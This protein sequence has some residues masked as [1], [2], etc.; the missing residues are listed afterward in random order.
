[1]AQNAPRDTAAAPEVDAV[2]VTGTRI[3][4][5]FEQ[6]TPVTIATIEQ[7]E[8]AQPAG[9][10]TSLNQLPQFQG[11]L[12]PRNAPLSTATGPF[13]AR[14]NYL[15]L[16]G[17]GIN[18][19][20]IL[21]DGERVPPTTATGQVDVNT[22]P[23]MLVSRVDVV[24]AGVSAV[25]GSD[26]V[27]GVVNYV[28]D[29]KFSGL[30]VKAQTGIS[31]Y[32]DAFSYKFG[33]A[34]GMKFANGRGSLIGSVEHEKTDEI[35]HR[36]RPLSALNYVRAGKGARTD[37]DV[38]GQAA[39]PI[40]FVP[41]VVTTLILPGGSFQSGPGAGLQVNA[42]GQLVP[43]TRG[44]Y[45]GSNTYVGGDGSVLSQNRTL[46]S[47]GVS[48]R[49]FGRASYDLTDKIELFAEGL[50]GKN[51]NP[52]HTAISFFTLLAYP[53][54]AFLP[55]ALKPT[56]AVLASNPATADT[57]LGAFIRAAPT[58][59]TE[60]RQLETS[61]NWSVKTGL[62][63]ELTDGWNFNAV[64]IHGEVKQHVEAYEV[65]SRKLFAAADSIVNP[66][67]GQVV[68]RITLTNPTIFPGCVPYN[69]FGSGTNNANRAAVEGFIYGSSIY[70][71]TNKTDDLAFSL[72][73]QPFSTWAGPVGLS[74]G[75]E[76]RRNTLTLTSNSDPALAL[77]TTGI[78]GLTTLGVK[79]AYNITNIG[80]A[81]GRSN[82][83]EANIELLIP[84]ANKDSA[85]G[86]VI[87]SGAGRW[88]NYSTSGTVYTWKGG[89][90]WEPIPDIRLRATRSRD[91]RAPTLYELNAGR[92]SVRI[93]LSDPHTNFANPTGAFVFGGGNP[94]LTPEK[95]DTFTA[96]VV[97]TPRFVPRLTVSLDYYDLKISDAITSLTA[98]Q[99]LQACENA[100]GSGAS[101]ANIERPLPFSDRTPANFPT[102][103]F[104]GFIN[105]AELQTK[106]IDIEAAY[107]VPVSSGSLGFRALANR[108]IR[109][110]SQNS[111]T[112]PVVS[113]AG[114]FDYTLATGTIQPKWRG[115]I[116]ANY[117][118]D[119]G[120]GLFLQGRYVGKLRMGEL[121]GLSVVGRQ[122]NVFD[123][124]VTGSVW[125]FDT[126]I[127][128]TIKSGPMGSEVELFANV[129]N[130]LNKKPPV[131]PGNSLVGA[132]YPTYMPL[133]DV[134][135][136]YYTV[137]VKMK[138]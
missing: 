119:S 62:R 71:T 72:S 5:G 110:A 1:M 24:T 49:M 111:T 104:A 138:F 67:N 127:S 37:A 55:N 92:T 39:F 63:G 48:T 99:V 61:E 16:R 66:A 22:I 44:T 130:L 134:M 38:P 117:K 128:Q 9:I 106:G 125:Y 27:T 124:K 8:V 60:P 46:I 78:R 82:V 69:P 131:I 100:G 87:V 13:A 102:S 59:L 17:V 77:N 91:I 107:S 97:L 70:D 52:Y 90:T 57:P 96:G 40:V 120:L 54:N 32:G 93:P 11:S 113:Q 26:A 65:D 53:Q 12:S 7:L 95:A 6:P 33:A 84:L 118:S 121:P 4:T 21:M 20:L 19:T 109:Y 68:C 34:G 25:Y 94:N 122:T 126:N 56:A 36:D 64:Y 47:G 133:Y 15:N 88:T 23:E 51:R 2:V 79:T 116:S 14:G 3:K 30:R 98:A 112:D 86:E 41:N 136:R 73:G 135:G 45:V 31:D 29:D 81:D 76:Y 123:H 75:A 89:A 129:N 58:D 85:I 114:Y 101:C 28:L 105:A 35:L 108:L 103:I 42:S 115:S 132:L 43:I 137:G 83:K 18:R 80:V 10:A 74:V 50:Y